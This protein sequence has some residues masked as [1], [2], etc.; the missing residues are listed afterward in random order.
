MFRQHRLRMVTACIL[1]VAVGMIVLLPVSAAARAERV[2]KYR[3]LNLVSDIPGMAVV[4][5]PLLLN[6]WGVAVGPT[7]IIW[8]NDNGSGVATT[9]DRNGDPFGIVVTIP[10]PAGGAP[11][12]TP[13]G[14]VFN[15]TSGFVV[16]KGEA[17]GKSRFIFVTE[18][19]TISGWN[20]EVDPNDAILVVDNSASGAVYKGVTMAMT[21]AGDPRIFVTNFHQNVVEIYDDEWNFVDSFTDSEVPA[22]FAPFGIQAF[23]NMV[24]V[25]YA[26]QK[27]DKHDDLAGP[28]NGFV[29]VFDADG[30]LVER[31]AA[32]GTLNSPWGLAVAPQGFGTFSG[33]LLV[34]NFGDGRINGFDTETGAFLG[35]LTDFAGRPLSID[36]LWS[37]KFL[38]SNTRGKR[39]IIPAT[40]Y[41]AA[42]LND[43]ADG[44]FGTL[45]AVPPFARGQAYGAIGRRR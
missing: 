12:S 17:S 13:T 31:F 37:I 41:F 2:S 18:D 16:T 28:G 33:A 44:L 15:P 40:M 6:P 9:Y 8:V 38:F 30:T 20:P 32:H 21:E 35:Q 42:G 36:G 27:P 29:D 14:I 3:Q 39:G 5:D 1:V 25:T 11:P 10:P 34:G 23:D 45:Q 22:D 24:W 4:T 26:K 19:G 7:G 43:E